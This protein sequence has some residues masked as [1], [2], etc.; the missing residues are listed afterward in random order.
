MK[1]ELVLSVNPLYRCNFRCSFCYLTKE[2]LAST[3]VL[4]LKVLRHQLGHITQQNSIKHIDLYGGEVTLLDDNYIAELLSVFSEYY[5]G[6]INVVTNLSQLKPWLSRPEVDLSVSWDGDLRQD[7]RLVFSNILSTNKP[8][9]VLLLASPAMMAWSEAKL[10]ETIDMLNLA[11]N[12]VSVEVK[13]YSANQANQ[14]RF[15]NRDFER[16]IMRWLTID[17]DFNFEFVNEKNI[18]SVLQHRKNA[19][20]DDHLYITPQGELAVLEFDD[21][22]REYFKSL[23]SIADYA[24]WCGDEKR[25]ITSNPRCSGCRFLGA[26]LSEHL[27]NETVSDDS[28]DGFKGLIEW[29]EGRQTTS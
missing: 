24:A 25:R 23:S 15:K 7:H 28:C 1:N 13:P 6:K 19:W 27:K 11:S 22:H 18:Q 8:V 14:Q 20:S 12:I 3:E 26:C 5:S 9:H 4:D 21:Q 16:F 29:Y 2:Q 17:R 10:A